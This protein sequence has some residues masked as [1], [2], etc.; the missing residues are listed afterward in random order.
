MQSSQ[1]GG[2]LYSD[3][4]PGQIHLVSIIWSVCQIHLVRKGASVKMIP[5][6]T[7]I[8]D[9]NDFAKI[10]CFSTLMASLRAQGRR[11]VSKKR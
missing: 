6:K 1:A 4:S 2:Q 3:T 9:K 8:R 7:I 5:S 11:R 10:F